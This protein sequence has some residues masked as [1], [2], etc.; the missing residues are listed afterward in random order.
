VGEAGTVANIDQ[1]NHEDRTLNRR[2]GG[3][4]DMKVFF[5]VEV[6]MSLSS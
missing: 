5:L 3:P 1:T 2:A 4:K 6:F